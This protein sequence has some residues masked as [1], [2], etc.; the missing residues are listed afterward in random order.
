MRVWMVRSFTLSW[1]SLLAACST[2]PV[3]APEGPTI[4]EIYDAHLTRVRS[5]TNAPVSPPGY[6]P[7]SK[8]DAVSMTEQRFARLYNPTLHLYIYAHLAG[9]E[10][11][12]VPGYY[13][14]FPLYDKIEYARA[15]EPVG[16]Q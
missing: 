3:L 5:E 4:G 16:P 9:A 14:I 7:E 11:V 12:P 8:P 1:I 2:H 15:G 6:R 13:T 10:R